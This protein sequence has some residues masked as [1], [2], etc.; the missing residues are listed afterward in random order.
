MGHSEKVQKSLL[1]DPVDSHVSDRE[2]HAQFVTNDVEWELRNRQSLGLWSVWI[3]AGNRMGPHNEPSSHR[4]VPACIRSFT[5]GP[6]KGAVGGTGSH[7]VN[8][9]TKRMCLHMVQ[10][11]KGVF[12]D[13]NDHTQIKA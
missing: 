12:I 7:A 3:S 6:P 1:P 5:N 2:S 11:K 10:I 9:E 13:K 8:V 4:T